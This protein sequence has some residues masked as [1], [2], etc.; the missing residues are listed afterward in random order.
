MQFFADIAESVG[1]K[2]VIPP[3]ALLCIQRSR[4]RKFGM[5]GGKGIHTT[6]LRIRMRWL[7]VIVRRSVR[8]WIAGISAKSLNL[9][10]EIS[11]GEVRKS[12]RQHY[13]PCRRRF[14]SFVECLSSLCACAWEA[15]LYLHHY[16]LWAFSCS[17]VVLSLAFYRARAVW[18]L[19]HIHRHLTCGHNCCTRDV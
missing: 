4:P 8:I 2:K 11:D 16:R 14:Q 7:W 18:V 12:A 5:I 15:V 10:E 6:H 13:R 19:H 17:Y 1:S 9:R 3:C